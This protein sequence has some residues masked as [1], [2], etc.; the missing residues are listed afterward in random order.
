[1]KLL[2]WSCILCVAFTKDYGG[3]HYP[4]NTSLNIPYP[5]SD[6]DF[7]P[8]FRP[9]ENK[10]P[11]YPENPDPDTGVPSFPWI[12]TSPGDPF[13]HI[14]SFPATAW[15][16][17]SPPPRES[18][19]FVPNSHKPEGPFF[20]LNVPLPTAA[21]PYVAIPQVSTRTTPP[22]NPEPVA[23]DPGAIEPDDAEP[24]APEPQPSTFD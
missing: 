20:S 8:P 13:H 24:V 12:L 21:K 3:N 18:P 10:I 15:W 22:P 7:A 17:P 6:R 14:P 2:L 1:M 4:L 16:I 11:P 5:R 23:V 9:S 19:H